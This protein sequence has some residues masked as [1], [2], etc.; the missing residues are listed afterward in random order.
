MTP[1]PVLGFLLRARASFHQRCPPRLFIFPRNKEERA[2]ASGEEKEEK[3]RGRGD[4]SCVVLPESSVNSVGQGVALCVVCFGVLHRVE[5][6]PMRNTI[7]PRGG[8]KDS[9]HMRATCRRRRLANGAPLS[10]W[11][12]WEDSQVIPYVVF[13]RISFINILERYYCRFAILPEV[14]SSALPLCDRFCCFF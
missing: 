1:L 4:P 6:R 12:I 14:S 7:R 9:M 3:D 2:E 11:I 5:T 8:L 10:F 13:V